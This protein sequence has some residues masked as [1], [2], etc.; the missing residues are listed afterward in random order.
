M[1]TTMPTRRTRSPTALSAPEANISLM[2]STS[3]VTRV[4]SRPT[5]VRSKKPSLRVCRKRKTWARRSA[6]A[7]APASCIRY[8]CGKAIDLLDDEHR[9]DA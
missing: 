6:I 1:M 4:T 8:I 9:G 5:G 7:R 3:L 2:A